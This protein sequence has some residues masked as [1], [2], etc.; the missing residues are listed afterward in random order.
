MSQE[1]LERGKTHL[2]RDE[3]DQ[4]IN[5]LTDYISTDFWNA[6]ALMMLG[7][8]FLAKGKAGMAA[9]I[10]SQALR[11][12]PNFPEALLN[13]GSAYRLE[14]KFEEAEKVWRL[15]LELGDAVPKHQQAMLHACIAAIHVN[16]R[17]TDKAITLLDRALEIAPGHAEFEYNRG[18][19]YLEAG[20]WEEGWRGYEAGFK[21]NVRRARNYNGLPLWDGSPNKRVIVWGEQG[22]GDEI[23]FASC[24]PDLIK[25]SRSVIFDCHPRLVNLFARSFPEITLHG[26]RK[27]LSTVNW[28]PD[29]EADA[30]VCIAS[31]PMHFRNRDQDFPGK[32]Y[33]R[34]QEAPRAP[35]KPR[36]GIAWIGGTKKT[37]VDQRTIPLR[38]WVP[39]LSS[40]DA[41]FFS[42]QYTPDAAREV[43]DLEEKT[44]MRVRHFPG[45]VECKDYDATATFVKSL[46]LVVTVPTAVYH[47]SNAIGVPTWTLVPSEPAWTFAAKGE[48][49]FRETVRFF[50][51]TGSD[52]APT[53]QAVADAL[54]NEK[55]E[56]FGS[57]AWPSKHMAMIEGARQ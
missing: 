38:D 25:I 46:D 32:P 27:L 54:S 42:L 24:L 6:E 14:H 23:L 50:R 55:A 52:W 44:G 33:L 19:A 39:V 7:V 18:L 2:D 22:I 45:C 41:D 20:R 28:V 30:V 5:V 31:L 43:C 53:I 17:G 56:L 11:I 1:L 16:G 21:A 49:W 13:M 15:A 26:T 47:L 40:I 29:T 9:V 34:A 12:K 3:M 48:L 8:A 51:Q 36:I 37:R 57:R 10:T 35:G 4:A